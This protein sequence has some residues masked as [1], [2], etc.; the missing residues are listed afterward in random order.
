[1]Q[2][3]FYLLVVLALVIF[4]WWLSCL[5]WFKPWSIKHL[6]MRLFWQMGANNPELLTMLGLLE[7]FGIRGHNARL[8]DLSEAKIDKDY[9]HLEHGLKLLRSYPRK[10]QSPTTLLSTDILDWFMDDQFR[11]KPFRHHDYPFNQMF[12]LQSETPNFMMTIHPMGSLRDARDYLKR[13]G[14]FGIKFDQALEGMRIR[15]QKG[16]FPPRFVIQRILNEMTSFSSVPAREN[17]LYTVFAEKLSKIKA[18][19]TQRDELLSAVEIEIDRTVY[20]AYNQLIEYFS[21][22]EPKAGLEDGVWKLPNGE[23][24]YAHLLRSN[25]TTDLT[26]EHVHEMGLQ[27]VARI[28]TEMG[29]ILKQLGYM[30]VKNAPRFLKELSREERFH[31][32]NTEKGRADCLAEYERILKEIDQKLGT[33]FDIRPRAAL[34]VERVPEF[35][36][37]TS[38]DAYYQMPDMGGKRPGVFYANLRDM[39]GIH[40]FGMKTLAYHEG[41]PGHHFQISIALELRG[42]PFFRRMVPFTAFDEGWALYSEKLA[43]E[44]GAYKDD[45]YGELGYLDSELFRA[46]RL[47]VDTGIHQ[48]CWTRQQAIDYMLDHSASSEES[49]ISE[50][51]RYIVMPGQACSYKIGEIKMVELRAKAI[52][53]L[54]EKFDLR[55][56]HNVILQNGAMPLS[57]LE[58]VVDGYIQK[59]LS[60]A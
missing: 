58:Q 16:C 13:L 42:V 53:A 48:T 23:A 52:R 59:E 37:K 49:V 6:Y 17:G 50:I 2:T 28:E 8:A 47:V 7:N 14:K 1:M 40:K 11:T 19:S 35:R 51:E 39:D 5:I 60:P 24:Y 43:R 20:P 22:L 34:K 45:P 25:T 10:N 55:K 54:G 27:E 32:P 15:E 57:L 21:E 30:D 31:F 29:I 36:E 18:S 56:Y 38:A 4:V 26:P 12:G 44:Q 9:A 46:V 3:I 33:V 41:I